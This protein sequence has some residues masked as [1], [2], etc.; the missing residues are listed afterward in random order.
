MI[1]V[2]LATGS[3]Y[4]IAVASGAA[5]LVFETLW[6]RAAGL[7]L[8]NG[9]Q[10]STVVLSAF[11]GGMALGNGLAAR[12]GDRVRRPLAIYAA[13]ELTIGI[14]AALAIVAMPGFA[15]RLAGTLGALEQAGPWLQLVRFATAFS[16][17]VLPAM[18]MGATLPILVHALGRSGG[19]FGASVGRAYGWNT[20]GAVAGAWVGEALL[21]EALG[22]RGSAFVAAGLNGLAALCALGLARALGEGSSAPAPNVG[23]A[24]PGAP[25]SDGRALRWLVGAALAGAIFLALEV[26]W[27]RFLWLF[28][29]G[30]SRLFA[31]MLALVLAGLSIGGLLVAR[32]LRDEERA[33]RL[34]P[35]LALGAA[36]SVVGSYALFEG[37]FRGLV[38]GGGTA[39]VV[40]DATTLLFLA[41]PLMLPTS[42]LSGMLLPTVATVAR[43]RIGGDA[44]TVGRVVLA[45]TLGAAVGSIVGGFVLL[46]RLG[47]EHSLLLGA[48]GYLGLAVLWRTRALGRL[49]FAGA[50]VLSLVCFPLFPGGALRETYVPYRVAAFLDDE[51]EL[52]AVQEGLLET[53]AFVR[54]ERFGEV[55][56]WRLFT[57]GYSMSGTMTASRRYMKAFVYLP[58]ALHERPRDALLISYGLGQTARALA[59]T[60][61]LERI[62]VVDISPD[63]VSTSSRVFARPEDDPL[64]D[65][66]VEVFLEDGRFFLQTSGRSYDLITAEPPPPKVDGVVNLY[67]LEHF[68]GV[69]HALAPG[70]IATYWLPVHDLE[71][72]DARSILAAFCAA[73]ADCTLWS[74]AGLEWMMVGTRDGPAGVDV[75]RF[76]QQ[77]SVPKVAAELAALGFERPAQLAATYLAGPGEIAA[78]VGD[79]LPVV[80]DFPARLSTRPVL[81]PEDRRSRA[82]AELTEPA[83][84]RAAFRASG[85]AARAIPA[86]IR[87]EA[88]GYF[89]WQARIDA[90]LAGEGAGSG[91][92]A[93]VDRL[94]TDTPLRTLPLWLL[95]SSREEQATLRR[96]P[97]LRS[98]EAEMARAAGALVDGHLDATIEHLGAVRAA[99][100]SGELA[101]RAL[102]LE[103]Y[104]RARLGDAEGAERAARELAATGQRPTLWPGG[105]WFARRFG[106]SSTG[107]AAAPGLAS[108]SP[109]P[110]AHRPGARR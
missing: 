85:F 95:G 90:T 41:G 4:A 7:S 54:T 80:D 27:F 53:I 73:F 52:V 51:S 98:A 62:D 104:V 78:F 42:V 100:P 46:P 103:R 24:S 74:G 83:R 82:W 31:A 26:V 35:L 101:A 56:H 32:W 88:L 5:A 97:A 14:F 28:V 47:V 55:H 59:D 29:V 87:E 10:A 71:V 3:V 84:A 44:R 17:M 48:A 19:A 92:L 8:G 105:G 22:I 37:V 76:S 75:A 86:P 109:A 15:G 49:A 60:A 36:A 77:W 67:T 45:N 6:Y 64:V 94:L 38:D 91:S 72:D 2:R 25:G 69:R 61:E 65:P 79:A 99:A 106:A 50:F 16:W 107:T 110:R 93:E 39:R 1:P 34:L 89:A 11:M 18:A 30:T 12:F 57:N 58:V 40:A 108:P 68:E 63:I 102:L 70:G 20:L 23:A 21:V 96:Q 81:D 13:L 33:A 9:V 43:A 66:R